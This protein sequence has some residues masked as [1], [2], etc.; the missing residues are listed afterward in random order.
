MKKVLL[1]TILLVT[2]F[3][4][5]SQSVQEL[6]NDEDFR[7]YILKFEELTDIVSNNLNNNK[8]E[9]ANASTLIEDGKGQNLSEDEQLALINSAFSLSAEVNFMEYNEQIS[10]SL[11][12]LKQKYESIDGE[13]FKEA[14]AKI[15]RSGCGWRYT[16]CASAVA[17]E[18]AGILGFC[19]AATGGTLAPLC[20]A[21]AVIW[22]ADGILECKDDY[23]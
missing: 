17:I 1:S 13:V 2:S 18:G 22:A 6:E 12:R 11:S 21:A 23:C 15:S 9:F 16:L 4:G 14:A 8:I 20:L 5:Y 7:T 10:S 3:L 19:T